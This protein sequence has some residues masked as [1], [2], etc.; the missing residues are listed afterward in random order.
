M[1]ARTWG[2]IRIILKAA[3]SFHYMSH[4]KEVRFWKVS[5]FRSC[6]IFHYSTH[7]PFKINT[8]IVTMIFIAGDDKYAKTKYQKSTRTKLLEILYCII[9]M[10]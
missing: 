2:V 10:S 7:L 3:E 8:V 5:N 9:M 4:I 1:K 6:T